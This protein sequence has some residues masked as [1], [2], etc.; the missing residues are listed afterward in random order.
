M[1]QDSTTM[2]KVANFVGILIGSTVLL[3]GGVMFLLLFVR[4]VVVLVQKIGGSL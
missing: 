2:Q 3:S 4:G 1:T